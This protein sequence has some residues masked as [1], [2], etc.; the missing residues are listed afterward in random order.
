MAPLSSR[1]N[2]AGNLNQN[3][4]IAL[5]AIVITLFAYPILGTLVAFTP[6]SSLTASIPVRLSLSILFVVLI[7]R[8]KS[9][10]WGRSASVLI[11]FFFLVYFIRLLWD[12]FIAEVPQASEFAFKF[13]AFCIPSGMAF[14][15]RPSISEI[16]LG[17]AVIAFGG[18]ACCMAIIAA[19]TDL[20]GIRSFTEQSEGRLFLDTVNPI[21]YGHVGV[22][23][24]LGTLYI[25][26][27]FTSW[28]WRT[29]LIF[30]SILGYLAIYFS[31]SRGPLITLL[32][33]LFVLGLFSKRYRLILTIY[34]LLLIAL[35]A[36]F[37]TLDLSEFMGGNG[38]WISRMNDTF[39]RNGSPEIR[40]LM[41]YG[42]LDQFIESPI[43]GSSIIENH[44]QDFPHNPFVES[45][46]ALGLGGL[47]IFISINFIAINNIIKSLR[48]DAILMPLFAIQALVAAQFSGS[49]FESSFMWMILCYYSSKNNYMNNK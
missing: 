49:L 30:I 19:T 44:F 18:L 11:F 36:T 24:L 3:N 32:I 23:T 5:M 41:I 26:T 29:L 45:A 22:S 21:T 8:T 2:I 31:G 16:K 20:S 17:W 15:C 4:A 39:V 7:L 10:V 28:W 1:V 34:S 25:A 9:Y 48:Q 13:I 40:Q 6:F 43:L 35:I 47:L 14:L 38:L 46:M 27:I 33:C 42:A 12:L 37:F